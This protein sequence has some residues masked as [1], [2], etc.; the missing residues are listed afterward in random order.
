MIIFFRSYKLWPREVGHVHL[1]QMGYNE[2]FFLQSNTV[3]SMF[4][5]FWILRVRIP[6]KSGWICNKYG[7]W[8]ECSYTIRSIL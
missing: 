1:C 5:I 3:L 7:W 8:M 2:V 4:H 6:S